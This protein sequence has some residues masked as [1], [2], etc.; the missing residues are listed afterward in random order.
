MDFANFLDF[1]FEFINKK[2]PTDLKDYV[3]SMNGYEFDP[4]FYDQAMD[5]IINVARTATSSLEV[6]VDNILSELN[7]ESEQLE[8][9]GY[10][11]IDEADIDGFS[12][13]KKLKIH[14]FTDREISVFNVV[15][16]PT[17]FVFPYTQKY[18]NLYPDLFDELSSLC[19]MIM[20]EEDKNLTGDAI[21]LKKSL[22]NYF[23]QAA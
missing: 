2:Q 4:D 16:I 1:D 11:V 9:Q 14:V 13:K 21:L 12:L 22:Q 3:G 7:D 5:P 18:E 23:E 15:S 6:P 8:L 17:E 19:R 10:N 20:L